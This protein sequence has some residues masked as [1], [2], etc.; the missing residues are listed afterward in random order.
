M[1]HTNL[2]T[3]LE[4]AVIGMSGAFPG[5][6]DLDVFWENLCNAK[7]SVC[8]SNSTTELAMG[9]AA[10]DIS[11]PSYVFGLGGILDHKDA[12][13]ATFFGYSD[14][15]AMLMDPQVRLFH[16]HTYKALED[17]GYS[18]RRS[19]LTIGLFGT[20]SSHLYWQVVTGI[21]EGQNLVSDFSNETFANRDFL[22]SRT[23]YKLN[24]RGPAMFINTACSSSLVAIHY[25]CRSVLTGEC[26][27]AI[28]GAV[29]VNAA[30]KK[31]YLYTEGMILSK[32]G[33]CRPFDEAASGTIAGEGIG[34]VV[35]KRLQK[36]M[37]DGDHI[38]AIIKGSAV[39]NDGFQ[40]VS[41]TAPSI[42]G[43]CSVIRSA[44]KIAGIPAET[45][46]YIEA[47]GTGT[48]LGDPIEITALIK[49]FN[50][51]RRQYCA[52]GSVK[53]N[54]G[55]LDTTAGMA[56]FLKTV[57][58]LKNQQL[59]PMP[60]FCCANP[61]VNLENS[62][63]YVNTSLRQWPS[64]GGV[65]LRA[66]VSSF[67]I[68]GTN[69]HLILEAA[70][71]GSPHRAEIY[72]P[73]ILP[74]SA[75]SPTALFKRIAQIETYLKKNDQV[76]L[77]TMAFTLAIAREQLPVRYGFVAASR[78]HLLQQ[79]QRTLQN[80]PQCE[81]AYRAA[82]VAFMF[83]GQGAQCQGMGRNIY[84]CE[85]IFRASMENCM[86]ILKSISTAFVDNVTELWT[87]KGWLFRTEKVQPYLFAFEYA[88]GQLLIA[89]GIQPDILI[90]HSLGEYVAACIA[91]V[92]E[93]K[94][95]LS[96]VCKRGELMGKLP[97]GSM[98]NIRISEEELLQ[99]LPPE[100]SISALNSNTNV[101]VSGNCE[102]I[103]AFEQCLSNK[104]YA[105]ARVGVARAFHSPMVDSIIE[106]FRAFLNGFTLKAPKIPLLSNF[107][108]RLMTEEQ[109]TST[110]Y[111][112]SQLRNTVQFKQG[113]DELGK[114]GDV[115]ALEVGPGRALTGFAHDSNAS[116]H[117][118]SFALLPSSSKMENE[119]ESFM[120]Q[121][122]QA[123][124]RGLP[125]EW[126]SM[127]SD[128]TRRMVSLP[129]YPFDAKVFKPDVSLL[130][131]LVS[132]LEAEKAASIKSPIGEWF[133]LPLWEQSPYP[134]VPIAEPLRSHT[135]LLTKSK[136]ETA[137]LARFP[138]YCKHLEI[139]ARAEETSLLENWLA[140][141]GGIGDVL[142]FADAF[143]EGNFYEQICTLIK[144]LRC[145]GQ[146]KNAKSFRLFL[147]SS[148][149][150]SVLGT[151]R[152]Q[153]AVVA[154]VG[155]LKVAS[156][157]FS[158]AQFK[159]I[160]LEQPENDAEASYY[161]VLHELRRKD[162]EIV[163][164]YRSG[165]R[166]IPIYRQIPITNHT[167]TGVFFNQYSVILI[168]G[169][170][171][172]I[173]L[174][175]AESLS[176]HYRSRLVLVGRTPV[177][178]EEKWPEIIENGSH[179][180]SSTVATL[181][182]IKKNGSALRLI[183]A[184]ITDYSSFA[185]L[186]AQVEN[187]LGK[188]TGIF[189]CAGV[190]DYEGV[191]MRRTGEETIKVM[192][193]KVT[194]VLVLEKLFA[195]QGLDFLI[196]CSS[197]GNILYKEK[198][199]QLGYNCGNEYL[200][201][202]AE[203]HGFGANTFVATINW[204]DWKETGMSLKALTK[205]V[206]E[207]AI[208]EREKNE[209]LCNGIENQEGF[210]AILTVIRHRWTRVIIST[211]TLANRIANMK[212]A[213]PIERSAT[214]NTMLSPTAIIPQ[215]TS[216]SAMEQSVAAIFNQYVIASVQGVNDNFF[217]L[218]GDSLRA[219][220]LIAAIR[221][222]FGIKVPLEMFFSEPTIARILEYLSIKQV[223]KTTEAPPEIFVFNSSQTR[224]VFCFPPALGYGI[225]YKGLADALQSI[226]LCC[227]NFENGEE[228]FEKYGQQ[229]RALQ[230]HGPYIVLGYSAGGT[231]GF[232][233]I[234]QLEKNG[235]EC[236]DLVLL[237]TYQYRFLEYKDEMVSKKFEDSVE[238]FVKAQATF[239]KATVVS[240]IQRFYRYA[241][242][243]IHEG[244]IN[245][246]IHLL[247]ATDRADEQ[248]RIRDLLDTGLH[249]RYLPF[250]E[251]SSKGYYEYQLQGPHNHLLSE[252]FIQHNASIV[253]SILDSCYNQ[254]SYLYL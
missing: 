240:Q 121:I 225:A 90:G 206:H 61:R 139:P 243:V 2:F 99:I 148:G 219:M 129:T 87:D 174:S 29:S 33:H 182:S 188:I 105:R 239:D 253:G 187:E 70:P 146:Q 222:Q 168:T 101:T 16:E 53:A 169:G 120:T 77:A 244:H 11:D 82:K 72:E 78:E 106:E 57:L 13:D 241:N 254:H 63:F 138:R 36:A 130:E 84:E 175:I 214:Q 147:I 135:L 64:T 98:L 128:K 228:A 192:A 65:P 80:W 199:G 158:N 91:G 50:T 40:K 111:W 233:V 45:V 213:F 49:A 132:T 59:T 247:T 196:I 210:E 25:A 114:I 43:Q 54:I 69:A 164:S 76:D 60:N 171:S 190:A 250:S 218:G 150:F 6:P 226:R 8:F 202:Y 185:P 220:E 212:K 122:V 113:L 216:F 116:K 34:V 231:L 67:G 118:H 28:A 178:K 230:S 96:I 15:E 66:G 145:I 48:S 176:S 51:Q 97:P 119:H 160:D 162:T 20:A 37:E 200:D 184:D 10:E 46:S 201:A 9:A 30:P 24:F 191:I 194:G 208:T 155:L 103:S 246:R 39:N 100:I 211:V 19:E 170:T 205:K 124:Q 149:A 209:V 75:K 108:G 238:H 167:G 172:G 68:G 181:A 153:P 47:H 144:V 115:I 197:L 86:S 81:P 165:K 142:V 17:A 227:F 237:D 94:D 137:L 166:F 134:P 31:G 112:C 224:T 35:L 251:L 92:I 252:P 232:E 161:Q 140:N 136:R 117:I 157:E 5:A 152:S 93:L 62:P 18:G 151:E 154:L 7:E 26:A 42:E 79:V 83:P 229:M 198:Y 179:P 1:N 102:K 159:I 223:T 245:S 203:A 52:L 143:S 249:S 180:L 221:S 32:D 183:C 58:C 236:S 4:V 127:F 71:M 89:K 189:H 22:V 215:G 156:C 56:G 123:W 27:L 85:P 88:V 44:L 133:Y 14:R 207:G 141:T 177:P 3:G 173:G 12:F 73:V 110:S 217:D 104:G 204:D 95:A 126:R 38:H 107:T 41:F 235:M 74:F 186:M 109:A 23:A 193:P 195:R 125:L 131:R 21:A 55:H 242:T 248:R 163:V 234:K